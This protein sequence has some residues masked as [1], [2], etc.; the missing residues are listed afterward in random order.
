MTLDQVFSGIQTLTL[1]LEQDFK[2]IG[3][4]NWS[5][6]ANHNMLFVRGGS[7][8]QHFLVLKAYSNERVGGIEL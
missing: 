7:I 3:R 8:D 6:F 2:M 4:I 1:S 5:G